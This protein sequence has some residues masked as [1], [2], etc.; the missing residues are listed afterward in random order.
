MKELSIK[1]PASTTEA[2]KEF[3]SATLFYLPSLTVDMESLKQF[4]FCSL[5]YSALACSR[6]GE[7]KK[8]SMETDKENGDRLDGQEKT[9]SSAGTRE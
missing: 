4:F 2:G 9:E 8:R 3:N 7:K 6:Q 5:I 1:N